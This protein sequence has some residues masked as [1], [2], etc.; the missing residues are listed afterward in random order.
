MSGAGLPIGGAAGEFV[1]VQSQADREQADLARE[2]RELANDPAGEL[3]ELVEIYRGRG[4]SLETARQV[5]E[6]LTL[7]DALGAH[8]RDDLGLGETL[9]A[10][11]IW[12]ALASAASFTLGALVPILAIRLAPENQI[13]AATTGAALVALAS[14][15]GLSARAGEAAVQRSVL[16]M[17]VW[18]AF[19]MGIT[20]LVGHLAGAVVGQLVLTSRMGRP[21]PVGGP[22]LDAS[23]KEQGAE[24][25]QQQGR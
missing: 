15:G 6:Q 13:G 19:A 11:P 9:P 2:R 5:A 3:A 20:A 8:A 22:A 1:S 18:E 12:A 23:G 4:L 24:Q 25:Q 16:R 7:H 14:R 17:L 21:R 10:R